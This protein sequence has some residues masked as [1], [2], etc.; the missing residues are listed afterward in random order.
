MNKRRF[1]RALLLMGVVGFVVV[2]TIGLLIWRLQRQEALD[3]QLIA[4]LVN[5]DFQK[6]RV[7]VNA[8]ADPATRLRP[9]SPPSL[10]QVWGYLVHHYSLPVN[11]SPTAF[12][13]ACGSERTVDMEGNFP[14]ENSHAPELIQTMLAHGAKV[15]E[16]DGE[17]STPLY[18]AASLNWQKTIA[19]LIDHRGDVNAQSEGGETPL[20]RAVESPG[21][22]EIVRLLLTHGARVNAQDTRGCTALYAAVEFSDAAKGVTESI[23]YQLLAYGADPNLPA[24][25]GTTV[26]QIAQRVHR[27]GLVA[28]LRKA[29]AKK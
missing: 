10:R 2:G 25:D 15:N 26:L 8:G 4:A 11:D 17:G 29:G 6:A 14:P 28:L 12:Q 21:A 18:C 24:H 9:T 19:V 20:I 27:P 1:K 13:N 7:L 23:V 22:P 3:R 5:D 16:K